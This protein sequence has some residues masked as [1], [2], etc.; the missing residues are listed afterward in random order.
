MTCQAWRRGDGADRRHGERGAGGRPRDGVVGVVDAVYRA[1]RCS[2]VDQHSAG[3][4]AEHL[5]GDVR[6]GS[7]D[8]V[9]WSDEAAGAVTTAPKALPQ[10]GGA[11]LN[12]MPTLHLSPQE[13]RNTHVASFRD[14][15]R[16]RCQSSKAGDRRS[17]LLV[18]RSLSRSAISFSSKLQMQ[19]S[20]GNNSD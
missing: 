4:G 19:S 17:C 1:R 12:K 3:D 14:S 5:G 20:F 13:S 8:A 6:S 18:G 11:P 15:R 16:P 7:G 9:G 10:V 2:V